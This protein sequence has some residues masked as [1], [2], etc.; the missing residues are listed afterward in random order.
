[1]GGGVVW[2]SFLPCARLIYVQVVCTGIQANVCAPVCVPMNERACISVGSY[3]YVCVCALVCMRTPHAGRVSSSGAGPAG[4]RVL[5][6]APEGP[7]AP[8]CP[9][10]LGWRPAHP[11]RG[12]RLRGP[13]LAVRADFLPIGTLPSAPWL[14]SCWPFLQVSPGAPSIWAAIH[15]PHQ[16]HA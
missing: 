14:A 5:Y 10:S 1:M 13:I 2:T 7:R 8:E 9:G 16:A 15:R 6:T 12:Q 11:Q 4:D 3:T